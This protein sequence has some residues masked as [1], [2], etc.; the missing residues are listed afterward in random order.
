MNK[1]IIAIIVIIIAAIGVYFMIDGFPDNQRIDTENNQNTGTTTPIAVVEDEEDASKSVIGQSVEGRDI[2][3]Y[4]FGTGETEILFV[5]GTHGG[6]SWNTVLVAYEAMDYLEKNPR[7]IPD[8]VKVTIIPVLNPDGLN[9]VVG[10]SSRFPQSAAVALSL[11]E[12]IPGR[13]NAN[14]V[15]IN[16]NFD[17]NWR[18]SAM[19]QNKTVSGGTKPFSEPE[20]QALRDYVSDSKPDAVVAWFSAAGGVYASSCNGSISEETNTLKEIYADASGYP[21]FDSFDFYETNGD[22]TNWLAKNKIPAISIL[23]TNHTDIEWNKNEFGIRALL[24]H[25]AD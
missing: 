1:F 25:Y 18:S 17:C 5:G 14:N 24:N 10:T 7:V 23:L 6:Y 9:E 8:N 11:S 4:H 15:D 19:W 20:S 21:A 16:R 22:M 13:F 12:T 2:T 3:A